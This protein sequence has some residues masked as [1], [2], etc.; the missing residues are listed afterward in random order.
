MLYTAVHSPPPDFVP[1]V[2][3]MPY[4]LARKGNALPLEYEYRLVWM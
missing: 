3:A 2:S 1:M 4:A